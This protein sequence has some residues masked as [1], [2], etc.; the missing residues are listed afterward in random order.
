MRCRTPLLL[1]PFSLVVAKN[2][3]NIGGEFPVPVKGE[4]VAWSLPF[5][6]DLLCVCLNDDCYDNS[7]DTNF[8]K[9]VIF[10]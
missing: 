7:D 8:G 2:G 1:L 9:W 3:T 4:W 6:F 5:S 10:E